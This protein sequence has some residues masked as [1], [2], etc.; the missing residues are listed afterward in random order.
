MK[1]ST[2]NCA[3]WHVANHKISHAFEMVQSTVLAIGAPTGTSAIITP[4]ASNASSNEGA[5]IASISACDAP[6]SS[7]MCFCMATETVSLKALPE[8]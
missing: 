1:F 6:A 4:V 3:Y 2:H 7:S 8:K 5:V